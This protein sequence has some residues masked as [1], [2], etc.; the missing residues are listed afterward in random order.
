MAD[1]Q[2]QR[3]VEIVDRLLAPDGCP[4]D[5]AQ[6]HETLKSHLVEETYEVLEAID[7]GDRDKLRE[8]LGDLLLQP[9][10]HAQISKAAGRWDIEA[11]A[12]EISDK[13][14]R[15]HPHVFAD[16]IAHDAETVL[17]NWD[18][19]KAEEKGGAQPASILAGVPK[20][21]PALLRAFEVS[22]RAARVG[23][24]WDSLDSVFGQVG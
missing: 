21:L 8:E 15:R 22:K 12:E 20:T 3:L 6:T 16:T 24:E 5:R 9:I 18:R 7:S 1:S 17:A 23:F 4:W 13:L 10:L 11:V 14:V 2:L 19:I